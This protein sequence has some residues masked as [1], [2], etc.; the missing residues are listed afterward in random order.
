[1]SDDRQ[2]KIMKST[3]STSVIIG[4]LAATAAFFTLAG[5]AE[6]ESNN[7]KSLLTSAGF[8]TKTP[9][10][11]LQKEIYAALTDRR[12]ERATYKGKTFY[13]FKDE[14]EGIAYVGREAEYQRY[15][16]LAIQQRIAQD[17]Y[18]A[19][20]MDRMSAYRWYGAYGYRGMYW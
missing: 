17:Y 13:V 18:M 16:Q 12:V 1:M 11:P 6:M 19:V 20:Q 9:Q 3:S 8:H 14:S 4:L 15:K 5:C 2:K 7:T 10:T